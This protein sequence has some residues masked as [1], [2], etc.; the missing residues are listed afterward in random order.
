MLYFRLRWSFSFSLYALIASVI[1]CGTFILD[2]HLHEKEVGVS[3]GALRDRALRH[4]LNGISN[5]SAI[6]AHPHGQTS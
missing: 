1:P 2:K 5:Q 4:R 6:K 3:D